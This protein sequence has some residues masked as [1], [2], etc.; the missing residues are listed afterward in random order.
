MTPQENRDNPQDNI[1]IVGNA[2]NNAIVKSREIKKALRSMRR[3]GYKTALSISIQLN[4]EQVPKKLRKNFK[5]KLSKEDHKFLR[6]YR[7]AGR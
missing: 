1:A 5:L 6:N 7:I 2:V 4:F 3:S